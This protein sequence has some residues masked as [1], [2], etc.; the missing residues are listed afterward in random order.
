MARILARRLCVHFRVK[1]HGLSPSTRHIKN[2]NDS[3]SMTTT[4]PMGNLELFVPSIQVQQLD[5][6][7]SNERGIYAATGLCAARPMTVLSE[8]V[9]KHSSSEGVESAWGPSVIK[10]IDEHVRTV[11]AFIGRV[12]AHGQRHVTR[13]LLLTYDH[14]L[15]RRAQTVCTARLRTETALRR[16]TTRSIFHT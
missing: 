9:R 10:V 14:L 3:R 8:G 2:A 5:K 16:A 4:E 15:G 11:H 13:Q 6:K 7:A 1:T 12:H